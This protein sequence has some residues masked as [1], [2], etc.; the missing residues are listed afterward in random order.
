M[1]SASRRAARPA[2]TPWRAATT[3]SMK[4]RLPSSCSS[5]CS[6]PSADQAAAARR[7]CSAPRTAVKSKPN[8]HVAGDLVLLEHDGHRLRPGRRRRLPRR[9]SGVYGDG[10]LKL[11]GEADVVHHQ[12]ARLV[13]KDAV[14]ARD[15]LHQP[16]AAHGLVDV[17]RVQAGRVE[18][19][20]PHVAHDHELERVVRVLE[21]LRQRLAPRLVADVA[22]PVERV[23][24]PSRS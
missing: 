5:T 4:R 12:A 6:M 23:A 10:L 18:A 2:R 11:V 24:R 20:Q 14:H 16:V 7:A 13:A 8:M 17:H 19:R 3:A 21:A 15:R 9:R 1:R 22:L